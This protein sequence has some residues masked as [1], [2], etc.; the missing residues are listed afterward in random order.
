M[1]RITSEKIHRIR[2]STPKKPNPTPHEVRVAQLIVSKIEEI[3]TR[4]ISEALKEGDLELCFVVNKEREFLKY[5]KRVFSGTTKGAE[6]IFGIR[7]LHGFESFEIDTTEPLET[8]PPEDEVSV[9]EQLLGKPRKL[10]KDEIQQLK[11]AKYARK[12]VH[13][14]RDSIGG[15]VEIRRSISSKESRIL[16]SVRMRYGDFLSLISNLT[17]KKPEQKQANEALKHF[18][19]VFFSEEP[20]KWIR[21]RVALSQH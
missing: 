3:L 1:K 10:S 19:K 4:K 5:E 17:E 6:K 2:T 8:E 11:Y 21:C 7:R 9:K 15:S 12:V 18:L 13:G 20:T 16:L 14:C